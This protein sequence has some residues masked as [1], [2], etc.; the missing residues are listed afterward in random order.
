MEI[1][2]KSRLAIT[3]LC[4]LPACIL[5]AG[6][7]RFYLGKVRTG[8]LMLLTWGGFGIWTLIDLILAVSGAMKDKEGNPIKNW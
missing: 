3:L 2:P 1:S 8:L 4:I 7:H 5:I 6:V